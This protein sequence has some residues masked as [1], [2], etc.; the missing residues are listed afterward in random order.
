MFI[1]ARLLEPAEFSGY[2][3]FAVPF[4]AYRPAGEPIDVLTGFSKD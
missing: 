1:P 4:K 2:K 3:V